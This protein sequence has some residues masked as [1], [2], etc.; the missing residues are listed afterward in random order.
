MNSKFFLPCLNLCLPTEE[1]LEEE[2]VDKLKGADNGEPGEEAEVAAGPAN[3]VGH[4]HLGIPDDGRDVA[5]VGAKVHVDRHEA[6]LPLV[7]R[8]KQM[9]PLVVAHVEDLTG[10]LGF[11][12]LLLP[13]L[14]GVAEYQ[15]LLH[16]LLDEC[17]I[18]RHQDGFRIEDV[19]SQVVAASWHDGP[20]SLSPGFRP[21]GWKSVLG[22]FHVG[23]AL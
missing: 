19:I 2:P 15:P 10:P 4:R 7:G 9:L 18:P 6:V 22:P 3:L 1:D 14:A 5:V 21:V 17:G 13:V 23:D 16:V 8:A 11:L 20:G 12:Y